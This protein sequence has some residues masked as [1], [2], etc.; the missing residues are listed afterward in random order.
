MGPRHRAGGDIVLI[1]AD[2]NSFDDLFTAVT[3]AAT[4]PAFRQS[5]SLSWGLPRIAAKRGENTYF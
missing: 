3:T 4:L 2:T 1:E 5:C